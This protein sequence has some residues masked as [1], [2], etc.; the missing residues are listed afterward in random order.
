MKNCSF[1]GELGLSGKVR[2]ANN[3]R[4][5]IDEAIRLGFENILIPENTIDIK[6]NFQSLINIKKISSINE[7]MDY[8]FKK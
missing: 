6:D 3:L 7:A 8:V 4:A 1:I 5:K 2:R